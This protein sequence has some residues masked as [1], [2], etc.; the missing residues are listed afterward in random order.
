VSALKKPNYTPAVYR[1]T[2]EI[3][4]RN[5]DKTR[6]TG[7]LCGIP[8]LSDNHPEK[9]RW[10]RCDSPAIPLECLA[11]ADIDLGKAGPNATETSGHAKIDQIDLEKQ[12]E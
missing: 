4:R 1:T 9:T 8:F 6:K 12:Y 2:K 7:K 10:Q 3:K 5:A 11:L